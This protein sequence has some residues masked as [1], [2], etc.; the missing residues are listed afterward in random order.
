MNLEKIENFI[1][2]SSGVSVAFVGRDSDYLRDESERV[3]KDLEGVLMS[4]PDIM[5]IDPEGM[6]IG[7]NEV[8]GIQ[9]F[10]TYSPDRLSRK[11]VFVYDADRT[12]QQAANALLKTLEEP[13]RY[14][15]IVLTTTRWHLLLPTMRSRVVKFVLNPPPVEGNIH[16][17]VDKIAENVWKVRRELK[18]SLKILESVKGSS[19][20]ELVKGL[21][22]E[23]LKGYLSA[24]EFLERIA[25]SDEREFLNLVDLVISNYSGKQ[26]FRVNALLARASLWLA[27]TEG[28]IIDM[29]NI[30]FFDSISRA[31]LP[32][33]NNH[34][35][36]YN[37][38]IRYRE[39]RRRDEAWSSQ[40]TYT[41]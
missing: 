14:A 5:V 8:R 13:P 1:R 24:F 38:A 3:V 32:N 25:T 4:S 6:E 23:N 36:T 7:I 34:L 29:E 17:W 35:T 10:L 28:K 26:L 12:N 20:E 31:R 33:F 16:P 21:S 41:V 37:I 27:E 11:Y 9:S 40:Q 18:N 22:E 30:R 39:V 19:S 15:V 2:N